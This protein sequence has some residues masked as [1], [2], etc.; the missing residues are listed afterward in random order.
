MRSIQNKIQIIKST[1]IS[2][3]LRRINLKIF[4]SAFF[5]KIE[6]FDRFPKTALFFCGTRKFRSRSESE[7]VSQ[8]ALSA[9]LIGRPVMITPLW[10]VDRVWAK[11]LPPRLH[12]DMFFF[13][14]S[15]FSSSTNRRFPPLNRETKISETWEPQIPKIFQNRK[16]EKIECLD[17]GEINVT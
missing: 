14:L 16:K 17:V 7:M 15:F 10:L 11:F 2:C 12:V 8:S 9:P 1:E 5:D 4:F 6:N 13:L 3:L